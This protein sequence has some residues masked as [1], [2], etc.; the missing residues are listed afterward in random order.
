VSRYRIEF[1]RAAA[2]ELR[3]VRDWRVH[4]ALEAAIL[5]LADDPRPPGC[6]KLSG[7][8]DE[9]RIRVGDWRVIY[10]VEGV[11][12]VVIVVAV[13]ARGGVYG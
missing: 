1:T 10:R 3:A 8:K 6:R 9:W 4:D 5:G 11:R 7:R 13:G 12:L 2:K